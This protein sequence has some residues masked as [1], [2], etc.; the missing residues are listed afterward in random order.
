[1]NH[2]YRC[3]KD[4]LAKSLALDTIDQFLKRGYKIELSW[5][6]GDPNDGGAHYKV[7]FSDV[8][9][10]IAIESTL[11]DTLNKCAVENDSAITF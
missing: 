4:A 7:M 6:P 10:V 8:Q 11:I 1:M 2:L 3:D 9:D 5:F